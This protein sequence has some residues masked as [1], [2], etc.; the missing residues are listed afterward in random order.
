MEVQSAWCEVCV[1]GRTFSVPQAYTCHK[2]SCSRT[3]KRLANALD[4]AKGV[5]QAKKRQKLEEKIAKEASMDPGPFQ[6]ECTTIVRE[7]SFQTPPPSHE[8]NVSAS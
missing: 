3:K 1:C 7:V 4:K 8:L 5:W 2:R 6:D